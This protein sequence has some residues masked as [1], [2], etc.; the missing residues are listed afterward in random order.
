VRGRG[1][2]RDV[3]VGDGVGGLVEFGQRG[4]HDHGDRVPAVGSHAGGGDAGLEPQ[5]D[6]VVAALGA[7]ALIGHLGQG[8]V[9]QVPARPHGGGDGLDIGPGFRVDPARQP[10][11]AIWA[12]LAQLQSAAAGPVGLV[13]VAVGVEEVIDVAGGGLDDLA[14]ILRRFCHQAAFDV[15]AVDGRHAGGQHVDGPA[16]HLQLILA[17]GAGGHRGGGMRQ[18][19]RQRRAGQ[20][21]PRP[22]A[23]GDLHAAFDLLGR[24]T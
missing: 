20:L 12:L 17:D 9:G 8:A 7:A 10:R 14:V 13:E 23:C 19:G 22:D 5:L 18:L 21:A 6:A 3:G 2:H 4:A 15:V 16:D 11:H 1:R 24:H